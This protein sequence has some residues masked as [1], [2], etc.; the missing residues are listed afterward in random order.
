MRDAT[1][2]LSVGF[3]CTAVGE[4]VMVNRCLSGDLGD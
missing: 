2:T 1:S 4:F 3:V